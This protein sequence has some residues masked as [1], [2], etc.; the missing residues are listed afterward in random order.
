V[1]N[2]HETLQQILAFRDEREWAQYHTP[3]NLVAALVV[4]AGELQ[5]SILWKSDEEVSDYLRSPQGKADLAGEIADVLIFSLLLCHAVGIDPIDA[6][7]EKIQQN[8]EKYPVELSRGK[9]LKYTQLKPDA[10]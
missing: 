3:R 9:S 2:L 4:E 5:E 7:K 8:A 10:E 6:I 1:D